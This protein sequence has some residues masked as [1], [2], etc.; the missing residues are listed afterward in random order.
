M[1]VCV[2]VGVVCISADVRGG[3]KSVRSSEQELQGVVSLLTGNQ[4]Q[5]LRESKP[6]LATEP[7]LTRPSSFT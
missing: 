1:C 2:G 4:T 3:Q 6:C 5:V 7:S